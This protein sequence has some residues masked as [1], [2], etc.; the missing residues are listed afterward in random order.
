MLSAITRITSAFALIGS[1]ISGHGRCLGAEKGSI[2][3]E[4]RVVKFSF[5]GEEIKDS[6]MVSIEFTDDNKVLVN[7]KTEKRHWANYTIAGISNPF[8]ID[9]K[10]VK[11]SK[12]DGGIS[13]G[14]YHIA[15]GKLTISKTV[16]PESK[17]PA[18]LSPPAGEFCVVLELEKV[19]K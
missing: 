11:D 10:I 8:Q 7:T 12:V 13:L 6:R 18:S 15:D 14:I 16:I 17:R 3:G 4:W 2:K 19:K 1:L 5:A 9:F